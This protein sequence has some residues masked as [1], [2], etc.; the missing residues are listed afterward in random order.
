MGRLPHPPYSPD[1]ALC[2]FSRFEKFKND[3]RL[4]N[5]VNELELKGAIEM[6][7]VSIEPD[8]LKTV[9]EH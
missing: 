8:P 6:A 7:C 5:D 1:L 2:G 3:L 4:R 9:F